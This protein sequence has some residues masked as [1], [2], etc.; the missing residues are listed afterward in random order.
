[1]DTVSAPSKRFVFSPENNFE[2]LGRLLQCLTSLSGILGVE[3]IESIAQS[4]DV[5]SSPVAAARDALLDVKELTRFGK[6]LSADASLPLLFM[7]VYV[8][9]LRP[10]LHV[11]AKQLI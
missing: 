7:A 8:L 4:L 3:F 5:F 6:L 9:L 1:V 2:D 11:S 10:I